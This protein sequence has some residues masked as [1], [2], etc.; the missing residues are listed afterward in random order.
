MVSLNN[1]LAFAQVSLKAFLTFFI[2]HHLF[3]DVTE[4]FIVRKE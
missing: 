4:Q 2:T 1:D 3:V